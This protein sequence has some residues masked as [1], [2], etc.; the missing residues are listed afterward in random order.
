MRIGA[1]GVSV[2]G[3]T[4]RRPGRSTRVLDELN[5]GLLDGGNCF[6][7]DDGYD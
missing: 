3:R 5:N 1:P 2:T 6:L 4:T 7:D